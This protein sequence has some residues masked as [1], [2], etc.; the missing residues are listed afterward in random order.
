MSAQRWMLGGL[1]LAVLAS[2]LALAQQGPVDLLPPGF[3]KPAARPRARPAPPPAARPAPP[4]AAPSIAARPVIAAPA[5]TPA[6]AGPAIDP[7]ALAARL[8]NLQNLDKLPPDQL[9]ALLGLKPKYDMPAGARR[10]MQRVGVLGA[11]EGGLPPFSLAR[12]NG[13]LVRA[14]LDGN[15]GVMVSRWG[16]ILLRRVLASRLDAPQGLNPADFA[17]ARAALLVRMGEGEAARALVQDVD[18]GNY[19]PALTQAA[20]DAYVMTADFTGICPVVAAV[21]NAR[22]DRE[23]QVLQAVCAVFS[24]NGAVGFAQLDRLTNGGALPRIDMLLAQKYAGAAGVAGK[25]GGRRAVTIEWSGVNDM[26]PWRYGMTLAT[27][28]TPPAEL[29]RQAGPRYD[30]IAA[31]APMLGLGARAEAADRAAAWGVLSASSMV[32][33]YSQIAADAEVKGAP[34]DRAVLLRDAYLADSPA[35]R[36]AAIRQLWGGVN[37]PLL[38]YGRQVTTAYAAARLP[39]EGAFSSDAGDLIAAMLAA[40]L[41]ANALRWGSVV[42]RGSAGWALLAL[43]APGARPPVADGDIASFKRGDSSDG[44]RRTGFL[45][46]GLA[47]LGRVAEPVR[48]DYAAK[49]GLDLDTQSRWTRAIDQAAANGN[50]TLVAL[51]AGLGMQGEGWQAMTPRYLYH[52]VGALHRV[53]LDGEARM[54]AAEAVARG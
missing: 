37:D 44:S 29:M 17:A 46:A 19:N 12:Q 26:T 22:K 23:W 48:R 51:L 8:P 7:T 41:D 34:A 54:I 28:L 27:G 1:G 36:L 33:L 24:G 2:G 14:A 11:G 32:D 42:E 18:A 40:G 49:L 43:A 20:Y 53:G 50:P 10:A 13:A 52:I 3:D 39:A 21:G 5:T 9:D 4:A 38:R 15:R 47:G 16:H 30:L 45:V 31:T 35:A 25:G 6:P